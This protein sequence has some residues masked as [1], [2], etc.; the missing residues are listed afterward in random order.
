MFKNIIKNMLT[1]FTQVKSLEGDMEE[2]GEDYAR[3]RH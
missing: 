3:E 1:L 2:R